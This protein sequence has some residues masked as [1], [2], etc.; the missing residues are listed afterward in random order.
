MSVQNKRIDVRTL[1]DITGT[2]YYVHNDEINIGEDM[3]VRVYDE[4]D[5]LISDMKFGEALS[6]SMGLKKDLVLRNDKTD[7][8]IVKI[9]NYKLQLIKRLFKKLGREQG[10]EDSG[11]ASTLRLTTN[12]SIHDLENKKQ[13][14]ID[15]LKNNATMKLFM[16]VNI[17]DDENVQKG[18]LMLLNIAEDLKSYGKM[19]VSPGQPPKEKEQKKP[20]KDKLGLDDI[21]Q[22]AEKHAFVSLDKSGAILDEGIEDDSW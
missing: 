10:V 5:Q 11:K 8:P 7:P 4:N 22:M 15:E 17:Y 12:I 6:Q 9:M 2:K 18:R 14:A 13:K 21:K 19:S 1:C 3:L 16:K 20:N